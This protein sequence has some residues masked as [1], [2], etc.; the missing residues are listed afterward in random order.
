[1]AYCR[2]ETADGYTVM[3]NYHLRDKRLSLK[4]RGLLSQ[5]LSLP[6]KWDMTIS[7][8]SKINCEC[9]DTIASI[10]KKLEATGYIT[11]YRERR[12]NG[13]Y[14]EIFYDIRMKPRHFDEPKRNKSERVKPKQMSSAQLSKEKSNKEKE[15]KE[16]FN[17]HQS[18]LPDG[19]DK[20]DGYRAIILKNIEYDLIDD[21]YNNC[22]FYDN[23]AVEK[24][25]SR[26]QDV[27]KMK[28]DL[29]SYKI[30]SLSIHQCLKLTDLSL[31][32]IRKNALKNFESDFI[33]QHDLEIRSDWNEIVYN[34]SLPDPP[35]V[36]R[37]P[38]TIFE[39]LAPNLKKFLLNFDVNI[40]KSPLDSEA[41]FAFFYKYNDYYYIGLSVMNTSQAM[42]EDFISWGQY[43][44]LLK[45]YFNRS[46]NTSILQSYNRLLTFKIAD[47][48]IT[49]GY[50]LPSEKKNKTQVPMIEIQ[51]YSNNKTKCRE[52]GDIDL[53]LNVL[54]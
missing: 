39:R 31:E 20:I 16:L 35:E 43:P 37:I 52:L 2:V 47:L 34:Y 13:T 8:L 6:E 50:V 24:F 36:L 42:I 48:L 28:R 30:S 41:E 15:S 40:C 17:I 14:G 26:L 38:K 29:H 3:S 21:Q 19:I 33:T 9:S 22:N 53:S 10:I 46:T 7:G 27:S 12:E 45:Y 54:P 44:E 25:F 49:N 18:I 5:I 11:R 4:A 51:R 1:M 32:S 23:T